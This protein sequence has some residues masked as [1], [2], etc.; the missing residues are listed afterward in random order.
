MA[1][2]FL[3]GVCFISF[4]FYFARQEKYAAVICLFIFSGAPFLANP[5]ISGVCLLIF[6]FGGAPFLL[7]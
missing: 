5:K 3:P 2:I 7:R 4:V 6:Y 1:L